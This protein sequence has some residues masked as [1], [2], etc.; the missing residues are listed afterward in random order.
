MTNS[1]DL[2]EPPSVDCPLCNLPIEYADV[3]KSALVI[4]WSRRLGREV[5]C[6]PFHGPCAAIFNKRMQNRHDE[7]RR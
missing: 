7:V 4:V 2:S 1:V 3:P 5:E 6:G